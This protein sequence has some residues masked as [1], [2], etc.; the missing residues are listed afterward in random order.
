M[1][2]LPANSK[3]AFLPTY[4]V[5]SEDESQRLYQLNKNYTDTANA[6]NVR[7][8]S[9]YDT[10]ELINGQ[11]FFT[12][13]NAQR[14]RFGYRKVFSI[15][16]INAGVTLTTAHGISGITLFT[17]IFGTVITNVPDYRPIPFTSATAVTA[18][19]EIRAD[20]TNI[21]IVNGATAPPITSGIVVLEYLKN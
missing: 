13:G 20:T 11:Q 17:Q 5:F 19:I 14:K 3:A 4:D 8:I 18:Q 16:A 7:E 21:Y 6:V 9:L 15:G 1:T 12:A 10:V 2:F